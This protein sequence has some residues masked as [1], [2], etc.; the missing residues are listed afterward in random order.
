MTASL[1]RRS[2][3]PAPSPKPSLDDYHKCFVDG[4]KERFCLPPLG[5]YTI[6]VEG[7]TDIAYLSRAAELAEDLCGENL[8]ALPAYAQ[9]ADGASLICVCTPENPHTPGRGGTKEVGR[10]AR[11]LAGYIPILDLT[12]KIFVV[13]DHDD[14]GRGCVKTVSEAGFDAGT[15]C[16]TLDPAKHPNAC[17]EGCVVIEDLLSRAIQRRFFEMGGCCC[18]VT[19]HDGEAVR[20]EWDQ[21]SKG[22]LQQYVVEHGEWRD[23]LEIGRIIARVREVWGLPTDQTLFSG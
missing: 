23:L 17:S 13:C 2:G 19:Y 7:H 3:A 21:P 14:A 11:F 12:G 22:L 6:V 10:L 20:Y 18:R 4:L 1:P 5:R 15:H 8:L 9:P 16:L